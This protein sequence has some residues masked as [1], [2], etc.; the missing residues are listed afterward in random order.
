MP[1]LTTIAQHRI[2]FRAVE[3]TAATTRVPTVCVGAFAS[4]GF[5][6]VKALVAVALAEVWA[7]LARHE[8]LVRSSLSAVVA[9]LHAAPLAPERHGNI[10]K[11]LAL[12]TVAKL[13][14][15]YKTMP[16]V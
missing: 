11:L 1:V 12:H 6:F 9:P 2:A 16:V 14:L 10:N 13:A 7:D 15:C 5:A 3:A 8:S 4:P